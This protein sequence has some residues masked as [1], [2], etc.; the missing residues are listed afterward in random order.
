MTDS[1]EGIRWKI[2]EIDNDIL[3]LIKKR[4]SIAVAMG[5]QKVDKAMPVREEVTSPKGT[6]TA[7]NHIDEDYE[8]QFFSY[9]VVSPRDGSSEPR[10]VYHGLIAEVRWR[11][12]STLVVRDIQIG[13]K[14]VFDAATASYT[15]FNRV[16]W[17]YLIVIV[18]VLV[19][20]A[21]VLALGIALTI[22]VARSRWGRA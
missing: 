16:P 13:T 6:W 2:E 14:E 12:D 20:T 1:V 7:V 4:M 8:G 22:A 18:I 19:P 21:I 3:D 10:L 11:G 9:V 17:D 5:H 15:R